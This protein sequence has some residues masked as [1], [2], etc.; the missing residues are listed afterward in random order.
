MKILLTALSSIIFLLNG[1]SASDTTKN[2]TPNYKQILKEY[3]NYNQTNYNIPTFTYQPAKELQN[4]KD[5]YNLDSVAGTGDEFSKITNLM[6]WVHK[7][8]KHDG[9]MRGPKKKDIASIIDYCEKKNSGVNCRMLA[10]VMNDVY[11]SMGF[12]SR[13]ITCMPK[14]TGFVECHVINIVYSNQ[15]KKWLWMDAS[16]EAYVVDE[17]Q[18]PLG[19]GEVRDRLTTDKTVYV[20]KNFN[21]NGQPYP[22]GEAVY[23]HQY[24]SK[25]LFRF[26][27]ALHSK[28]AYESKFFGRTYIALY[29][30]GYNP[31]NRTMGEKLKNILSTGYII[32]ND[33]IFWE[34]P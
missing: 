20:N 21:W 13:V 9:S 4:I 2:S 11:L 24:M 14:A 7:T 22:G 33:K 32:D 5:D 16:F 34:N 18:I 25:N 8:V 27:C 30:V 12:K 15:Y 23:L 6:S 28:S 17:N 26:N 31:K 10:T 1:Y 3:P 29:P 19:I